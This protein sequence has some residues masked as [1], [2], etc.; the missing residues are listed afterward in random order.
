MTVQP[1]KSS[2]FGLS[3]A[4]STPFTETGAICIERL[5]AH[6]R[7]V[8]A[9]GADSVTL[10]GTTGEGFAI[11]P[12]ERAH[13]YAAFVIAG[14]D[15]ARHVGAAVIAATVE[16][17]AVQARQALE[18]DCRHILVAPPFYIK[19]VDDDGLFGWHSQLFMALGH[20][21][22]DIIVYNLPSQTGI[23]ISHEL[24]S[25][26]RKAHPGV[27]IGVKDSS[28]NWPYTERMLKEHGDIA[29]LIGDERQL[30]RAV[31]GGGQGSICGLA[32]TE[33]GRLRKMVHEGTEDPVISA[34]VDAVVSFP[35]LQTVKALIADKTGD[36]S[37]NRV[38]AP[39][40]PLSDEV[41]TKAVGAC[42]A[43]LAEGI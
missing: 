36:A 24:V 30:A 21:A 42:K 7:R 16:E 8:M 23:T 26:L 15:F 28:G 37:W 22:R 34:L 1:S 5:I 12:A 17:A 18:L 19:G 40:S 29:I 31:R 2:R 4:L 20:E 11:G 3:C 9:E 6:A 38:R 33:A 13:V 10:F 39:I 32:N 41:R 14:F 35:V 43:A 25:R 27:I